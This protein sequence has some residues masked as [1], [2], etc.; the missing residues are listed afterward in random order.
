MKKLITSLLLVILILEIFFS[1]FS[2]AD[3]LTELP[4]EGTAENVEM[5]AEEEELEKTF[6]VTEDGETRN[7]GATLL[8]GII[9]NSK[10]P[11]EA[12]SFSCCRSSKWLIN[13]CSK[14]RWK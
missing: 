13:S 4:T 6:E 14:F 9:R 8:D 12:S 1:N 10:L 7:I 5:T 2:F 3:D 11:V